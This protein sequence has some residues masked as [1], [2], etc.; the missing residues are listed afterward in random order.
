[1]NRRTFLLLATAGTF[2]V[3]LGV[4]A[5]MKRAAAA[6]VKP[7]LLYSASDNPAGGH[8]LTRLDLASGQMQ[9]VAVPVRGHAVLPLSDGKALLFGRRPAFECAVVKFGEG[10]I[11]TF[12]TTS[13]RHFDGHGC[14]SSSGDVLFTTEN[15]YDEKRGVLGIRDSKTFQ[16]I[17]EYD[18]FGLDPHDVQLMPDGKTLVVANGGIEQHPDFG[19]RKLNLDTMQPSL[20]YIDAASGK[21]IDE[22][23]LPDRHLSIRHL[24]ATADGDVGVALQYEGDLYRQQPTSLVAWQEK[25]SDLQLLDISAADVALFNGYMADLAY[26]PQQQI[27]AVSSPRGNHTSF[28]SVRERRFL[29]AH[30]LPEPSGVA[31][32]ADRQQF[33]VSD[34]TGGIHT[35]PSPLKTASASLLLQFPDRLWDNHLVLA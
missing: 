9:S 1:M 7:H 3:A 5:L 23:R 2:G 13:G 25:G 21:K 14:L 17:G 35:F 11:A 18:T 6:P 8:F 20:V 10:S 30:P 24:I 4:G 34:A 12:A 32:L 29:H 33:L 16:H 31:F 19:R 26:D 27:L 15:A 22:Y 28:W